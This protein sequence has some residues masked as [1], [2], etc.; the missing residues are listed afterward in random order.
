[1]CSRYAIGEHAGAWLAKYGWGHPLSA[2]DIHPQDLAPVLVARG[3]MLQALPMCWGMQNPKSGVLVINAR[4]ETA[5]Q[6]PMFSESFRSRRC[7]LPATKFYEWD[8]ERQRVTFSPVAGGLLY[9]CGLYRMEEGIPHFVILTKPA[10][11]RIQPIH[12]RMPVIVA[13]DDI[14]PWLT[15]AT[16][17]MALLESEVPFQRSPIVE[18][19]SLF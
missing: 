6:K 16:Q 10:N 13:E 4:E 11:E 9:L 14:D 7:I 2:N 15:D 5:A 1:M 18:E 19:L 17:A 12:D 8:A 3:R